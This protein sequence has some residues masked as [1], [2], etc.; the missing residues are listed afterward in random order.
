MKTLRDLF[1]GAVCILSAASCDEASASTTGIP[2]LADTIQDCRGTTTP[3]ALSHDTQRRL[4]L[5]GLQKSEIDEAMQTEGVTPAHLDLLA[6]PNILKFMKD[7][8]EETYAQAFVKNADI[9]GYTPSRRILAFVNRAANNVGIEGPTEI[10]KKLVYTGFSLVELEA[11]EI[12]L[13]LSS[14]L[15][16]RTLDLLTN[17]KGSGTLT[18]ERAEYAGKYKDLYKNLGEKKTVKVIGCL[19]RPTIYLHKYL[20]SQPPESADEILVASCSYEVLS[21]FNQ[22]EGSLTPKQLQRA[23][24]LLTAMSPEVRAKIIN[25]QDVLFS[26]LLGK[27]LKPEYVIDILEVLSTMN[28]MEIKY[29]ATGKANK[30]QG[31]K[32]SRAKKMKYLVDRKQEFLAQKKA[33]KE[34]NGGLI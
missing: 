32:K 23:K 4:L 7:H 18:V 28:A 8:A 1:C 3:P 16:T 27:K 25:H 20:E 30:F 13:S 9:R 14:N 33:T 34:N 2:L 22:F 5:A 6:K 26:S 10:F 31:K 24:D 29:L 17:L 15:S 19:L 11:I 12:I 21:E